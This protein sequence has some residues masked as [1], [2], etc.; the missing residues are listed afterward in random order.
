MF[1]GARAVSGHVGGLPP[2]CPLWRQQFQTESLAAQGPPPLGTQG[3]QYV[4]QRFTPIQTAA[5]GK[6]QTRYQFSTLLGHLGLFETDHQQIVSDQAVAV[7]SNFF[8]NLVKSQV[9]G[10]FAQGTP[11][12]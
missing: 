5:D 3:E 8:A 1:P 2:F 12:R 9:N 10:E 7:V 4:V 11:S 6:G